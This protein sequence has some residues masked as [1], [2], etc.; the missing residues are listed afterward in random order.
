MG[1]RQPRLRCA[2]LGLVSSHTGDTGQRE[3]WTAGCLSE[4][5][6]EGPIVLGGT[7]GVCGCAISRAL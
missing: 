7:S 2:Y 4:E 6:L 3:G 1:W 5:L